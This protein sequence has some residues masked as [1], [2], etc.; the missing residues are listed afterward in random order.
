MSLHVVKTMSQADIDI[1]IALNDLPLNCTSKDKI[2]LIKKVCAAIDR[3]DDEFDKA[4]F[5]EIAC[6]MG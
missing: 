6:G 4:K 5:M 1:A 2:E 3:D